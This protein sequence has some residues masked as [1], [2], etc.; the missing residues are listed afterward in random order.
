MAR[1]PRLALT[2]L[3][4]Q[5]L[6]QGHNRQA[7]FLDDADRSRYLSLLREAAQSEGLAVHAYVLLEDRVWFLATP[8]RDAALSRALQATGRRYV[9]EFNRRHDRSG[10]LWEGRFRSS[11]VEP[12]EW[13]LRVQQ[14]IESAPVRAGWVERPEGWRWSSHSH[15]A[16]V[17]IDP[18]IRPHASVWA[19]GNT[20]FER[21]SA[22]RQ[23]FEDLLDTSIIQNIE[24]RLKSG[25][26]T[27][28]TH[29]QKQLEALKGVVLQRRP[30]GRPRRNPPELG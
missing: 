21:E 12:G 8:E 19:L 1:L 17:T 27:A 24:S 18:L 14:A 10:T 11:L 9:R 15:H 30:V 16:G 28:S 6:Q 3:P 7:V 2:G 22:Y 29:W 20:P 13:V 5:V 25:I 4:H 23:R 26:P